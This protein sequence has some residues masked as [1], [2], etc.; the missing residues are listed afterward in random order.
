MTLFVSDLDGTLLDNQ[1]CLPEKTAETLNT[2]LEKGLLFTYATARSYSS[3]GAITKALR[4]SLPVITYSGAVIN[5]G[6]TGK[7]LFY[8][9]PDKQALAALFAQMEKLR[10][11]PLVYA[12]I[13][14]RERCSYVRGHETQGILNYVEARNGN[15]RL[16][17][18]DSFEGLFDGDIFYF[19]YIATKAQA[20]MAQACFDNAPELCAHIQRDTYFKDDYWLEAYSMKANKAAAAQKLKSSLKADRLVCFGDNLNDLPLFRIADEAYAVANAVEEVKK[21]AAA[22]IPSNEEGGVAQWLSKNAIFF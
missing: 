7:G 13:D 10:L 19:S 15:E 20:E 1:G 17:P 9:L 14:G 3:A 16:R 12:L 5:E 11:A 6:K 21:K 18:V 8:E 22:V 2:L 4:L